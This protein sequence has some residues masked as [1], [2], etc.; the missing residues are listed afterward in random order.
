MA[1]ESSGV[2]GL[3]GLA[4]LAGGGDLGAGAGPSNRQKEER[5]S[6]GR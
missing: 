1:G 2:A 6:L 5:N 4:G 3:A